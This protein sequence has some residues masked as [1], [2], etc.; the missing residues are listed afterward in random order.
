ML[1]YRTS[2]GQGSTRPPELLGYASTGGADLHEATV[3]GWRVLGVTP[4]LRFD[5]PADGWE[6]LAG[7]AGWQIV[8]KG[9]FNPNAHI[10]T[11]SRWMVA[12]AEAGGQ[13]WAVPHVLTPEG[14]RSFKVAYGGPDFAPQLTAEQQAA[15]ALATEIR[16]AITANALP[17][18]PT[19][20]RWAARLL[21][22]VYCLSEGSLALLGMSEDLI[23]STLRVAAGLYAQRG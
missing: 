23:D 4:A 2:M 18:I 8:S 14:L 13:R 15:L 9:P 21:P 20:A 17:D 10:R 6:P 22:L 19:R 3:D 12:A 5:P 11:S 16:T 7:A 1:Y